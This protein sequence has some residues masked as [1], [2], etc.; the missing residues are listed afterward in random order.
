MAEIL[1]AWFEINRPLIYFVYG[2]VFFVTGL[3]IALQSRRNSR[4][5]L[6]RALRW[7]AGFGLTHGLHEWG[8]LFIPIQAGFLSPR[9]IEALEI[10]DLLLLAVSFIF[11]FQFGIELLRPLPGRWQWLSFLPSAMFVIWLNAV[12]GFHFL[13]EAE[14]EIEHH[15][16]SALARYLLGFPGGLAAAYGL[17]AHA[18]R[19]IAPLNLPH[20]YRTL[21]VAGLSLFAYALF[22]GLLVPPAPFFP[23]NWFNAEVFTRWVIAPPPLFRSLAG[24][25]LA[26]TIIR[27]LEVFELETE[28]LIERM[29]QA[30]VLMV[31]RERIARELHDGAI[32]QAY[33]AGLQAQALRKQSE[34][35][36]AEKLDRLIL[37]LNQTIAD[38]RQFLSTLRPA[39]EPV[40][41]VEVLTP[42]VEEIRQ[43]SGMVIHLQAEDV[44]PLSPS[45]M[46][47]L[48]AFTREALTN[49]V[50]H[51]SAS[52][53]DLALRTGPDCLRLT[54][55]DNGRGMP[56]QPRQGYGLRHMRDRARLLG[57]EVKFLP[58]PRGGTTVHLEIPLEEHL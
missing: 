50:R 29:E 43:A 18:R 24:S 7:L 40:N 11:L 19:H 33:T 21:R 25:I 6:A 2:Q 32:Q 9:V 57:G 36:V 30:Q 10:F 46:T 5:L 35:P 47:H 15:T 34:G 1:R 17:R 52:Q 14:A 44:P 8:E 56:Q 58:S 26:V 37:T 27:A 51:A 39:S 20:I 54:I 42:L 45:A 22:G 31:E 41:P 23:A 49:A 38:M 55:T 3:A 48:L 13:A 16:A 28:R 12:L 4:L 53:I